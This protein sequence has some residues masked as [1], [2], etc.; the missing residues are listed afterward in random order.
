MNDDF[1]FDFLF[2]VNHLTAFL[3][4]LNFAPIYIL[5]PNI[6]ARSMNGLLDMFLFD[7]KEARIK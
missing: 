1:S 5:I 6:L 2:C 7:Y 3:I 4:D